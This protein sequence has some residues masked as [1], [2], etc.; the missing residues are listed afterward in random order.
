[1][2]DPRGLMA[3]GDGR[4][5]CRAIVM[6]LSSIW[7]NPSRVARGFP[8]R[9]RAELARA[10]QNLTRCDIY[11]SILLDDLAGVWCRIRLAAPEQI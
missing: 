6:A 1:M 4:A 2:A 11:H 8:A 3:T 10:E 5:S 9:H 7:C